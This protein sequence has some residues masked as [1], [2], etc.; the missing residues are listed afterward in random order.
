MGEVDHQHQRQSESQQYQQEQQAAIFIHP[1]SDGGPSPLSSPSKRR[2]RQAR[3]LP[4][5]RVFHAFFQR[6]E[7]SYH[8]SRAFVFDILLSA[9]FLPIVPYFALSLLRGV[10]FGESS[11][12]IVPQAMRALHILLGLVFVYPPI[13]GFIADRGG[14]GLCLFLVNTL[15]ALLMGLS[16]L[17]FYIQ[18]TALAYII[19]LCY[20]AYAP[21]M[22]G[23]VYLYVLQAFPQ[24]HLGKLLGL[25]MT[26]GGI[27]SL[28][29][30]P[31]FE[32]SI[33]RNVNF[34][35]VLSVLLFF[36]FLAY[37]L[38]FWAVRANHKRSKTPNATNRLSTTTT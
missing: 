17:Q 33:H 24:E 12:Y 9:A 37:G 14:V 3:G 36:S 16:L 34:V 11:E 25:A 10:Y 29:A 5:P 20:A 35:I 23:Q 13:L 8:Q 38:L 1:F 19:C 30:T 27:F 2:R 4:V 15:G 26:V 18:D 32:V 31:L 28:I 6:I 7:E 22:S 21:L